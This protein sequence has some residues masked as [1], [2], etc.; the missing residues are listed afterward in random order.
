MFIIMLFILITGASERLKNNREFL[1][2]IAKRN[3]YI[4]NTLSHLKYDGEFLLEVAKENAQ[5]IGLIPCDCGL[6]VNRNFYLKAIKSNEEVFYYMGCGEFGL[7]NNPKYNFIEDAVKTNG[8]VLK[9]VDKSKVTDELTNLALLRI[10]SSQSFILSENAITKF[11]EMNSKKN[12]FTKKQLQVFFSN[13]KLLSQLN[14][15]LYTTFINSNMKFNGN[16]AGFV[17]YANQLNVGIKRM[18]NVFE[19]EQK[20]LKK[21]LI[22]KV[23]DRLRD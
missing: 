4:C 16:V 9:Y 22:K 7:K 21:P 3:A 20:K 14:K 17:K 19:A 18:L 12:A 10:F 8:W 6:Y 5:I 13:D 23:F 11:N 15:E 1:I 2:K